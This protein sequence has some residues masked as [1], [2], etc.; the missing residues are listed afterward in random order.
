MKS[1]RAS[2]TFEVK[3]K[4]EA[5]EAVGRMSLDKQFHGDLKAAGKGQMLAVRGGR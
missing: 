4:P 5:D 3:M 1:M 2:G